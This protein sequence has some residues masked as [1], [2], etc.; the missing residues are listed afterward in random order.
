M[1]F[2]RVVDKNE[3]LFDLAQKTEDPEAAC[4][5][6]ENWLETVTKKTDELIAAARGYINSSK[7]KRQQSSIPLTI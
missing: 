1:L 6:L 3:E 2:A 7:T 4:K 5:S